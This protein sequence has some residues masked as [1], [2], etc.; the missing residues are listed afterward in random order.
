ML[1]SVNSSSDEH[2]NLIQQKKELMNKQYENNKQ[3]KARNF[4]SDRTNHSQF[5]NYHRQ[6]IEK[7]WTVW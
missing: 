5:S 2:S 4:C 3:Q 6:N 1:K 7:K